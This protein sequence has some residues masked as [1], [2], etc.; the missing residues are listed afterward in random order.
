LDGYFEV[1][2]P[3]GGWKP[4]L[5]EAKRPAENLDLSSFTLIIA[6]TQAIAM[7]LKTLSSP[8]QKS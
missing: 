6:M 1:Y 2:C 3:T 8:W 7:K 5:D 4:I